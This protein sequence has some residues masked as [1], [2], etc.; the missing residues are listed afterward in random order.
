MYDETDSKSKDSINSAL[1]YGYV[2]QKNCIT[3]SIYDYLYQFQ[4]GAN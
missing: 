2:V 1:Q 3:I 4:D